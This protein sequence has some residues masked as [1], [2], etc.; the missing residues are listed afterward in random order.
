MIAGCDGSSATDAG[1]DAGARADAGGRIDAGPR[2]AGD[3]RMDAGGPSD[4]GGLDAAQPEDAGA[5]AGSPGVDAGNLMDAAGPD[6]GTDA[7][8]VATA[9]A[10]ADGGLDAGPALTRFYAV[11]ETSPTLYRLDPVTGAI[12]ATIAL[13][14]GGGRPLVG[15]RGLCYD[16]SAGVLRIVVDNG[17]NHVLGAVD[18]S[19][20]VVSSTGIFAYAIADIACGSS[21]ALYALTEQTAL[22]PHALYLVDVATAGLTLVAS[23]ADLPAVSPGGEALAFDR[24]TGLLFRMSG[25][26]DPK[27]FG[28]VDPMTGA[29][30]SLGVTPTP[31]GEAVGM[32]HG[33]PGSLYTLH[34]GGDIGRVD[35]VGSWTALSMPSG[36]GSDLVGCALGP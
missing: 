8:E 4:A 1:L 3:R 16:A 7:G 31:S 32:C 10:G 13:T 14:D 21:G 22:V 29:E 25:D 5:D 28:T 36:P 33:P 27:Y 6:G 12:A 9:D 30:V 2:D 35:L 20:G 19:T 23:L 34:R 11:E 17:A 24:V 15:A 18:P 26:G